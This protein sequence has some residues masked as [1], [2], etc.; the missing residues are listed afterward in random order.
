[1]K[2]HLETCSK[3]STVSLLDLIQRENISAVNNVICEEDCDEQMDSTKKEVPVARNGE[4]ERAEHAS[5]EMNAGFFE[6]P[7]AENESAHKLDAD[8]HD[9]QKV[10]WSILKV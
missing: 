3:K 5:L 2:I 6:Q 7:A 8:L 10:L 4:E 1:M 9:T